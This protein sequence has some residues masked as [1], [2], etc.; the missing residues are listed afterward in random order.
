MDEDKITD[1]ENV[2]ALVH[3]TTLHTYVMNDVLTLV[4]STSNTIL[5]RMIRGRAESL[6]YHFSD[7]EI[8]EAI[9]VKLDEKIRHHKKAIDHLEHYIEIH[10]LVILVEEVRNG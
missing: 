6:D 10:G 7:Y 8:R 1:L 9:A 3:S 2:R 4:S 5:G